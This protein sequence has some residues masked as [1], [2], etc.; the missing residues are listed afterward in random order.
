[1]PDS[2]APDEEPLE[3]EGDVMAGDRRIARTDTA[4]P[5]WYVSDTSYRPIPIVWFAGALIL[6][7]ILQPALFLVFTVFLEASPFVTIAAALLGSGLIWHLAMQRGMTT[8]SFAWR[9]ATLLM[10]AFFFL[11]T[12]LSALA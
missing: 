9:C 2:S 7:V 12:A 1:M 8:A 6:Q 5:D 3:N 10:L 4:L 11:L